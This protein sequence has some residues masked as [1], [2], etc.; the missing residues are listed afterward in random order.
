MVLIMIWA[1]KPYTKYV[2]SLLF[3]FVLFRF[4]CVFVCVSSCVYVYIE[5]CFLCSRVVVC[6]FKLLPEFDWCVG[7]CCLFA[8]ISL[9]GRLFKRRLFSLKVGPKHP[10]LFQIDPK[11]NLS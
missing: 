1:Q 3:V 4:V 11:L 9:D 5:C 7:R 2:S 10:H 6:V 8:Y